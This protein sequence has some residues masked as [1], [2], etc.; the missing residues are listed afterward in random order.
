MK[1]TTTELVQAKPPNGLRTVEST[2]GVTALIPRTI[3][4]FRELSVI[5]ANSGLVPKDYQ[6][7]PDDCFVA[8]MYGAELGIPP[9]QAM[10][11]IAVINGK[12]GIYGDILLAILYSSPLFDDASFD[13]SWEGEYP[14]DN[15]KAICTMGRRLP[16]GT[17]KTIT[18]EFSV[19]DAKLAKLWGKAGP[20]TNYPRRQIQWKPRWWTARDLFT[21]LL[22]GA[23]S[24]E[25]LIEIETEYEVIESEPAGETR[26]KTV[27]EKMADKATSLDEEKVDKATGEVTE[28]EPEAPSDEDLNGQKIT[29]AVLD[30][31][32]TCGTE[33]GFN[34]A[35]I[36]AVAKKKF[37]VSKLDELTNGQ[38]SELM[39]M[40]EA[41]VSKTTE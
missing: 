28:P 2:L 36:L 15:F 31:L 6:G 32:T 21:D 40:M 19:A 11:D 14:N 41:K 33:C 10:Q 24:A 17:V 20:W 12:P 9:L 7:K 30:S 37:K 3:E 38:A 39:A 22:R 18:R 5:L 1:E 26:S 29:P 23:R 35:Q 16:D 27:A 25:D 13:E 4:Q 34:S 8:M